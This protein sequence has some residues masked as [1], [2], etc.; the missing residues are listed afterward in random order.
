MSWG[1]ESLFRSVGLF[2][3]LAVTQRCIFC[4]FWGEEKK[5]KGKKNSNQ[6][7]RCP[8]HTKYIN[9]PVSVVLIVVRKT[10]PQE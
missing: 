1:T 9:V 5:K 8:H 6:F 7:F 2:F 4:G 10:Q 3:R